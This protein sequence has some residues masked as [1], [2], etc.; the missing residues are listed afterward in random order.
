M[1][2]KSIRLSAENKKSLAGFLFILPWLL[3]V[4][5]FFIR[6]LISSITYSLSDVGLTQNGLSITPVGFENY[7][8]LFRSDPDFVRMFTETLGSMLYRV[9]LII[10]LGIFIAILLNQ[11]FRAVLAQIKK[12]I[13][14]GIIPAGISIITNYKGGSM[15]L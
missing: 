8:A 14:A 4:A 9:P 5:T 10:I 13:P 12:K 7:I 15:S 11:N 1:K 3:G 2:R 6:P